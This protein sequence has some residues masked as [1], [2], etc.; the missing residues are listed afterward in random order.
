MAT[1]VALINSRFLLL[2]MRHS[3]SLSVFCA[4]R[5]EEIWIS[6]KILIYA[7]DWVEEKA[8]ADSDKTL[9]LCLVIDI[10]KRTLSRCLCAWMRKCL[11]LVAS[12]ERG[13]WVKLSGCMKKITNF[14]SPQSLFLYSTHSLS[15]FVTNCFRNDNGG[16]YCESPLFV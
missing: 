12:A 11:W 16:K 14:P 1:T 13:E 8:S 9:C 15:L 6:I 2:Y 7:F 3:L 10:N 4:P 5:E